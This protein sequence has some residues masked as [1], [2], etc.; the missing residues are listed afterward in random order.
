MTDWARIKAAAKDRGLNRKDFLEALADYL[1]GTI[2][3]KQLK[4]KE[5]LKRYYTP[6][7]GVLTFTLKSRLTKGEKR[8]AIIQSLKKEF[9]RCTKAQWEAVENFVWEV[10]RG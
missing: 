8:K 5:F 3:A 1:E 10:K 6:N 7:V 2:T 4:D 9:P